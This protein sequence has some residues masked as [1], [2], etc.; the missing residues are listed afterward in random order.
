[1]PKEVKCIVF[2]KEEIFTAFVEHRRQQHL[3]LPAGYVEKMV[4]GQGDMGV[5]AYLRICRDADQ[6][7]IQAEFE[8]AEIQEALI[9]FC[10][11]HSIPVA[12]KAE[13]KVFLQGLGLALMMTLNF[14]K[15]QISE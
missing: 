3:P 11:S 13:K 14:N 4:T 1:V 12:K 9:G 10:Q 7:I 2:S 8:D 6:E 5:F 15:T